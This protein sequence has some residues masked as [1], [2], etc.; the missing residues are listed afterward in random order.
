MR[1]RGT[2][3]SNQRRHEAASTLWCRR[4]KSLRHF[5]FLLIIDMIFIIV[6]AWLGLKKRGRG[7]RGIQGGNSAPPERSAGAKRRRQIPSGV[8]QKII[9]SRVVKIHHV[10]KV[11]EFLFASRSLSALSAD[12]AANLYSIFGVK[13]NWRFRILGEENL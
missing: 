10:G 9:S 2:S 3:S 12:S 8:F 7:G 5:F 1:Q 11:K 4:E 13:T 6:L